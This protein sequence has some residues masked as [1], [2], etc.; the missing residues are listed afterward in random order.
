MHRVDISQEEEEEEEVQQ[1]TLRDRTKALIALQ[2]FEGSFSLTS[3][4]ATL[5]EVPF[6]ELEAKIKAS[7]GHGLTDVLMNEIWATVLAVTFFERKLVAEK[8][9]WDLVVQKA[10]SWMAGLSGLKDDDL[11]KLELLAEGACARQ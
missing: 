1:L 4:L 2:S 8:E 11:K 3:S 5:L 9:V 6:G 10:K 7:R